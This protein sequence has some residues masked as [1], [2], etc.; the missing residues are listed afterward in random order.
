MNAER[1]TG[2]IKAI[3]RLRAIEQ[4]LRKGGANELHDKDGPT[5]LGHVLSVITHLERDVDVAR[6]GK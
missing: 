1:I 4:H 6:T 2:H 5:P 3:E